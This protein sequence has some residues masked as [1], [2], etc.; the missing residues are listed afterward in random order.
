[1]RIHL[2]LTNTSNYI[3]QAYHWI[4]FYQWK[5]CFKTFKRRYPLFLSIFWI[6]CN[7]VMSCVLP[8]IQIMSCQLV[9]Q[10]LDRPE[11]DH[12]V[13]SSCIPTFLAEKTCGVVFCVL[14]WLDMMEII[15]IYSWT[16]TLFDEHKYREGGK[17]IHL[18]FIFITAGRTD[19]SGPFM[20]E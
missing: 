20:S 17:D 2:P 19:C 9:C 5:Y 18:N 14:I 12:F 13:H 4:T 7:A 10:T 11:N 8:Q 15:K 16:W 3:C 1:M 6:V